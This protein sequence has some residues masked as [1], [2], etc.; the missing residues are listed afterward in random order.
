MSQPDPRLDAP[1][2][3]LGGLSPRQFMRRHWQRRPLLIRGAVAPIH[4]LATRPE[5]FDLAARDDVECRC[6]EQRAGG[7]RLRHGPFTRRALPPVS[8]AGW[9]LLVQGLDLH[10]E[11]AHELLRAFDFMAQ[12]RLDDLMLSW[13]SDGGGVGPHVDSY[14]VFLLQVAGRRRWRIAEPSDGTLRPGLPLR[15]LANFKAQ[16]EWLL[17]PGDMLYLPP[18]WGHEGVAEGGDCM[19]ASI[20]FRAP[21]AAELLGALL[22]RMADE[23]VEMAQENPLGPWSRRHADAGQPPT[24][25]S[26]RMPASLAG[27]AR[28]QMLRLQR[29]PG[30]LERALGSWCTE[31]KPQ[32]W[33]EPGP[34]RPPAHGGGMRLDRR[35]RMA[36]DRLH[37]FINGEA[38]RC[39]GRDARVLRKLADARRLSAAQRAQLSTE[40]AET[41]EV[42]RLQGWLHPEQP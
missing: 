18:G 3:L 21:T 4:T 32:V 40:A 41:L 29:E 10:L 34:D 8:R 38:Y 27:F 1:R 11:R 37:L 28:K 5:L 19:T 30:L 9:T 24:R 7:W 15:I 39:G 20:G 6:I 31:P 14:D 13:A 42:W 25:H 2:A 36:Y 17:E 22:P 33:F 12:A 16:Q 23:L 26:G 35:T